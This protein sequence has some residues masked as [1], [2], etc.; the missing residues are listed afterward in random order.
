MSMAAEARPGVRAG[1]AATAAAELP[2][3]DGDLTRQGIVGATD[4]PGADH[5]IDV[6]LQHPGSF[7]GRAADDAHRG[8]AGHVG[9]QAADL[10]A[11]SDDRPVRKHAAEPV[12]V[13]VR[14]GQDDRAEGV[15]GRAGR[16]VQ[17]LGFTP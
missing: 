16:L 17:G 9:A 10:Q 11:S 13:Q 4:C 14:P 15:E 7:Q 5:R 1:P 6:R 3:Q 8:T 12:D 2:V